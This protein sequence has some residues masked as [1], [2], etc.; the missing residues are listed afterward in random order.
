MTQELGPFTI[1]LRLVPLGTTV[2]IEINTR[3][4]SD[5]VWFILNSTSLNSKEKGKI[6]RTVSSLQHTI[7]LKKEYINVKLLIL[8]NSTCMKSIAVF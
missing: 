4:P 3:E 6:E 5:I 7:L 8:T 1:D 2:A